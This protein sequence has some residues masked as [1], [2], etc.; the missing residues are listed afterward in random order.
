MTTTLPYF[1][2][3]LVLQN[4]Q[5]GFE[6]KK[7]ATPVLDHGS[8]VVRILGAAVLSYHREIYNCHRHYHYPKPIVDGANA[9]GRVAALGPDALSLQSGQ[10]IYVVCVMHDRDDPKIM[11]L[12]AFHDRGTDGSENRLEDV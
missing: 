10:H 9:I 8:A 1:H 3:A 7:I 4:E 12:S 5:D 11:F 6:A 2:R